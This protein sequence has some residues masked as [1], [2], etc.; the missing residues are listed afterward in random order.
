MAGD[1]AW[2]W[3]TIRAL[4]ILL[5]QNLHRISGIVA[6]TRDSLRSPIWLLRS[7]STLAIVMAYYLT[8]PSHYLNQWLIAE[9]I[10]WASLDSL[11][12]WWLPRMTIMEILWHSTQ[13]SQA[14]IWNGNH[15]L[16]QANCDAYDSFTTKSIITGHG[17]RV[18]ATD[19]K[20]GYR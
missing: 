11:N 1:N 5:V 8:A 16:A 15:W 17:P 2:W 6:S 13:I 14:C 12:Q 4:T 7:C 9:R 20:I 10:V 18:S 19:L 3:I